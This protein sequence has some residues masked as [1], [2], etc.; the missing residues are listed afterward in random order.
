MWKPPGHSPRNR[1]NVLY[2]IKFNGMTTQVFACIIKNIST[3][4]L[5]P[6][7]RTLVGSGSK[8]WT[9]EHLSYNY[10]PNIKYLYDSCVINTNSIMVVW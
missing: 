6:I 9:N 10:F 4:T 1:Y 3:D 2:N 7:I 8:I 5:I